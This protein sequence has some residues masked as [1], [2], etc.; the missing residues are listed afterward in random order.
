MNDAP[1]FTLDSLYISPFTKRRVYDERG[2]IQHVPIERN[3]NPTG[4]EVMDR[5]VQNLTA[6]GHRNGIAERLGISKDKLDGF[7]SVL[8][9]MS[10]V[11]FGMRY[12]L[13]LADDYLRYSN[14]EV[15]EIA[16]RCG[17]GNTAS[18]Y[19]IFQREYHQTPV[20]RRQALRHKGDC[21]LYLL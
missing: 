11:E 18:M 3:L 7:V 6:G 13:R 5:I 4:I 8:T 19:Y 16:P 15:Q 1:Q 20:E 21:G 12:S 2:T 17:M 14:L 9:G 10:L